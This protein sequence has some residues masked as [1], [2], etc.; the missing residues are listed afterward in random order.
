MLDFILLHLIVYWIFFF[1]DTE[2]KNLLAGYVAMFL[3][4]YNTAQVSWR[5]L[6]ISRKRALKFLSDLLTV[7]P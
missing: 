4:D 7:S 1:Q 6:F 3:D 2:D 5:V